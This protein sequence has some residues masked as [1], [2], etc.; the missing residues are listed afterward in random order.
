VVAANLGAEPIELGLPDGGWTVAFATG[1]GEPGRLGAEEA[2]VL[3]LD[4]A[5]LAPPAHAGNHTV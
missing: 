4:R 5:V 3:A 1:A 2:A